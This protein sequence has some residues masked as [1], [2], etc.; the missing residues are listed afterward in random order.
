LKRLFSE[1]C[2][3][4][5]L[6]LANVI[7]IWIFPAFVTQDGPSHL[8]NS[9]ILVDI[10][11][12]QDKDF[13]FCYLNLNISLFPNLFSNVFLAFLLNFF[14][15]FIAEKL[16][17]TFLVIS[18]PLSFR[19]AIRTINS[20][21]LYLSVFVFIF[22]NSF[23]LS[24]GFY[25]FQ[26]SLVFFNIFLGMYLKSTETGLKQSIRL[27]FLF[28]LIY[29]THPVALILGISIIGFDLINLYFNEVF[30][31]KVRF[32]QFLRPVLNKILIFLPALILFTIYF[33]SQKSESEAI[34]NLKF[35][36]KVIVNLFT[37]NHL[38]VFSKFEIIPFV[39]FMIFNIILFVKNIKDFIGKISNAKLRSLLFLII[40]CLFIYFFISDK[41]TGGYFLITRIT[42]FIYITIILINAFIAREKLKFASMFVGTLIALSILFIRY[43]YQKDLGNVIVDF[44]ALKDKIPPHS[45]VFYA[46]LSNNGNIGP[47]NI[48]TSLNILVHMSS[49][50]GTFKTL[51]IFN[52]YEANTRYFPIRWKETTNPYTFLSNDEVVG[53]ESNPP[54]ININRY[55]KMIKEPVKYIIIWGDHKKFSDNKKYIS[56]LTQVMPDYD[57]IYKTPD[58]LTQLYRYKNH[59]IKN[60]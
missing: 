58:G 48:P 41:L 12:H 13:Y 35:N 21:N 28:L 57:L 3:F 51:M 5:F 26:W 22:T 9:Q 29:F 42:I 8:Y 7:Y 44:T 17:I 10:L 16:F 39:L 53:M 45:S 15:P 25:N 56:L 40:F 37:L 27:A 23:F 46:G 14:P 43:P 38:Y 33:F 52:N 20:E 2:L 36:N 24:F 59:M 47:Y 32:K 34:F 60:E 19:F 30:L 54:D 4:Y 11:N 31:K 50:L 6:I 18:L 55:N 49:Y 1:S